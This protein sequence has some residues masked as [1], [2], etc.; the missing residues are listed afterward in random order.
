MPQK[1]SFIQALNN[2]CSILVS[3]FQNYTRCQDGRRIQGL[4]DIKKTRLSY[5]LLFTDLDL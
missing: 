4:D 1:K 5:E 3:L 2:S